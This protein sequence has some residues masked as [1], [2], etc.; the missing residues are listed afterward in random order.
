M[1]A[2]DFIAIWSSFTGELEARYQA[3]YSEIEASWNSLAAVLQKHADRISSE[4]WQNPQP[5]NL[6]SVVDL[7]KTKGSVFLLEPLLA[8][9]RA[10]S[11]E[12]ALSAIENYQA[13]IE[14]VLRLLPNSITVSRKDLKRA[15]EL[16]GIHFHRLLLHIGRKQLSIS[17]RSI[18]RQVLLEHSAQRAKYDGRLLLLLSRAALSLLIPWQYMRT[19]SLKT[20]GLNPPHSQAVMEARG[21]WLR[22]ISELRSAGVRRLAAYNTW[23]RRLP[24]RLASALSAGDRCLSDKRRDLARNRWQSCFRH[25]SGQQRV[26]VAQLELESSS[27]RLLE[28]AAGISDE[29]LASVDDEHAQI[30]SELDKASQWLADWKSSTAIAPFPPPEALFVSSEDRAD[31]WGQRLAAAGRFALPAHI[32]FVDLKQALPGR[33]PQGRSL[34]AEACFS[35]SLSD[36]GRGTALI[37]FSE[38]EDGHR[39]IIREIE[40]AR[41]VAA[42]SI[43][44]GKNESESEESQQVVRDG[45]GNALS[46]LDY[47]KKTVTDC[48]PVVEL[49]LTEA[50]A[51]TFLRFHARMEESRLGFF[52]DLARQKGERAVR[53]GTKAGLSRIRGGSRWLEDRIAQFNSYISVKLGWSPPS[54]IALEPVV[55]RAYLGEILNLPPQRNLWVDSGCGR[56][57]SE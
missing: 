8:L 24:D 53:A 43:E 20:L 29:L 34:A 48:R 10:R 30:L 22:S 6:S 11:Q 35:K 14:N 36:I 55:R 52:K 33:R 45:I 16:R 5:G 38:A 46:L 40:R 15:L 56:L 42:Y 26:I 7:A 3:L 17:L 18:A 44:V 41:E 25:W 50:I 54:T 39:A 13:G 51:L 23:R 28:N 27:A 31:E 57:P 47:Q 21:D 49:L 12:R 9:K 32:E 4:E 2:N 1:K 37:G 19:S